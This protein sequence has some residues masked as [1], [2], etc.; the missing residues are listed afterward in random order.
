MINLI[1][2]KYVQMIIVAGV[3]FA[4]GKFS[5]PDIQRIEENKSSESSSTKNDVVI[6][7]STTRPDGTI[8]VTKRIDKTQKEKSSQSETK[9]VE[10]INSSLPN[11]MIGYTYGTQNKEHGIQI[12]KRLVGSLYFGA[13]TKFSNQGEVYLILS[14]GF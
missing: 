10:I 2:N 8:I 12:Q 3:F 13:Q 6:E 1:F 9:N 7:R 5:T 4:I 11:F 14:Y